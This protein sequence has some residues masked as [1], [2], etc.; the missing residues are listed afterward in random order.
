[1]RAAIR[2]YTEVLDFSM[3]WP[4][5]LLVFALVPVYH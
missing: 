3:A 5:N 1:M 4:I 2:H